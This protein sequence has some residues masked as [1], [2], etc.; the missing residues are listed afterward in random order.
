MGGI[1]YWGMGKAFLPIVDWD[2]R[3][4][5]LVKDADDHG[6]QLSSQSESQFPL[7]NNSNARIR[8]VEDATVKV[9]MSENNL[10]LEDEQDAQ[11]EPGTNP[12]DKEEE[13]VEN[14]YAGDKEER[15]DAH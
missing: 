15:P 13:I 3:K 1:E 4:L 12:G 5:N 8:V 11:V 9:P 14:G 2:Y 10:P 6:S 7:N